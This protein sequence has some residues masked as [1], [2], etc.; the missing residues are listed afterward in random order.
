[1]RLIVLMFIFVC[2]IVGCSSSSDNIIETVKNMKME[3]Y[4][5][6]SIGTALEGYFDD[7]HLEWT[8]SK[9]QNNICTVEAKIIVDGEDNIEFKPNNV[10]D[11]ILHIKQVYFSFEYNKKEN[12]IEGYKIYGTINNN[13]KFQFFETK[14]DDEASVFLNE[15]YDTQPDT[16]EISEKIDALYALKEK[17]ENAKTDQEARDIAG[18]NNALLLSLDY[19]NDNNITQQ[20]IISLINSCIE[21]EKEI[22]NKVDSI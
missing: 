19:L 6:K 11:D 7:F 17:V 13:G 15:I 10:T 20:E 12:V 21:T 22:K 2:N 18:D 4:P 14:N 8:A 16:S 5:D 3:D 9:T 1:M